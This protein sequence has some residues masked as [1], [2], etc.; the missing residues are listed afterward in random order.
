MMSTESK[1]A[2]AL[3]DAASTCFTEADYISVYTALGA[4]ETYSAI[5][6][7]LAIAARMRHSLPTNLITELTTWLDGYAGHKYEPQIRRL[8]NTCTARPTRR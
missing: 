3:A 4:G 2:W 1:L 7:T 8:L 5:V 6:R